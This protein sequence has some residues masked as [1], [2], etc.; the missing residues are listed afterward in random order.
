[1]IS[2]QK[3]L[4][5]FVFLIFRTLPIPFSSFLSRFHSLTWSPEGGQPLDLSTA[6][7]QPSVQQSH[8]LRMPSIPLKSVNV[9]SIRSFSFLRDPESFRSRQ[10]NISF[11]KNTISEPL[12]FKIFW[13][14][15][16][17]D[18]RSPPPAPTTNSRLR[19]EFSSAA[20][21]RLKLRSAFPA[22]TSAW[23]LQLMNNVHTL[24]LSS[25]L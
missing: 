19:H 24:I 14:R 23:L 11:V 6:S 18:P 4:F 17:S 16:L 21:Q 8:L 5:C 3:Y 15:M 7:Y 25:R 1:M 13:G 9:G 20:P 2:V 10:G 22:I 12:G